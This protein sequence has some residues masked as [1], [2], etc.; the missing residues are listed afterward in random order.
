MAVAADGNLGNLFPQ[1]LQKLPWESMAVLRSLP[2]T[3]LPSFHF[4]LSYSVTK[5]VGSWG[6][7]ETEDFKSW[8]E[9]GQGLLDSPD[10]QC[11]PLR[12]EPHQC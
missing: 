10:C 1:D 12:L 5:E 7:L 3:R 8:G 11:L 6:S 2:V 9:E 4:L